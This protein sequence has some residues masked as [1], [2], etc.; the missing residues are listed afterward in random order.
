MAWRP[1]YHAGKPRL[2]LCGQN[3]NANRFNVVVL[4]PADW[5]ALKPEHRC[6]KCVEKIKARKAA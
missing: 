5:N 3:G 1:V 6:S 2:P 4:A